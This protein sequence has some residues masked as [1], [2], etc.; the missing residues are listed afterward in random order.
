MV[1]NSALIALASSDPAD[2]NNWFVVLL[3]LGVVF[4][5]L[6]FIVVMTVIMSA[7][8]HAIE[9]NKKPE[10]VKEAPVVSE[11]API[12]NRQEMIAAVSACIAEELGTEVSAIRI[13]SVKAV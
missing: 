4:T 3:G 9:K 1:L 12:A 7:V 10:A 2:M 5:G 8:I 13:V 6:L 11:A